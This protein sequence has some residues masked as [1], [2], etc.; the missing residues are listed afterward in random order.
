MSVILS[1]VL[2]A[3]T[4]SLFFGFWLAALMWIYVFLY[5]DY[6]IELFGASSLPKPIFLALTAGLIFGGI[7][8]FFAGLLIK[9]LNASVLSKSI[10]ISFVITEVLVIILLLFLSFDTN[11]MS[12]IG[13]FIERFYDMVKISLVLLI[14]SIVIGTILTKVI[15]FIISR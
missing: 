14:P 7:Q 13:A 8:G 1:S 15:S 9:S 11:P 6:S 2:G 3:I 5:G 12:M 4:G 10:L